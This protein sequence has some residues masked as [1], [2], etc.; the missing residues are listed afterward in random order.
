[1]YTLKEVVY[2]PA[3]PHKK[4]CLLAADIG[5]TNSN[6]GF[7]IK[8]DHKFVLLFSLHAKSQEVTN[9]VD[10][11][12]QVLEYAKNNYEITVKF[13]CFAAA[14]VVSHTHDYCKP[15][16]LHFA[17]KSQ[18]ILA[19]TSLNCAIIVND[20][21]I[22]GHGIQVINQDALVPINVGS[23][24]LHAGRGI[25]GAG[26]GVGKCS[27]L[28]NVQEKRYLPLPS[29]GG[30]ADFPAQEHL[31]YELIEFIRAQEQRSCNISWEDVLSGNGIKRIYRFFRARNG[32]E[33]VN[34]DIA[35]NGLHPDLIFKNRHLDNHCLNTY[36]L[37]Q[38]FYARCAKDF[39]LDALALGGLYI[40]GG[41][42][43]HNVELFKERAFMEE[44]INCGKQQ[45]LLKHIP[46]FVITD[47][48]VSLYG[49]AAYMVLE[50]LCD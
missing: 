5:G 7:F 9:F 38:K 27:L 14:G 6:F 28:W 40:A 15:T 21:E 44:F 46:I 49:A 42:A 36:L 50:G 35:K 12:R 34:E 37:Y 20:F 17:I 29:E 16:N 1:M 23:P 48:N 31:E 18:E 45:E 33:K 30:H 10:L 43:A 24:Q 3:V 25:V 32:H 13:S 39:A 26:T 19:Q 2:V 22:I 47:Y 8:D 11:V 4:R 41:I